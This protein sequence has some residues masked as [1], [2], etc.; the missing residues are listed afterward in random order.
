MDKFKCHAEITDS[1][2]DDSI[3]DVIAFNQRLAVTE[4]LLNNINM[5]VYIYEALPNPISYHPVQFS[6]Q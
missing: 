2:C 5:K 1:I 4:L 6:Y 3:F